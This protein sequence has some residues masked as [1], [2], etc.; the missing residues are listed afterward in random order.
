MEALDVV[1]AAELLGIGVDATVAEI[2]A[3]FRRVMWA[4]RPDQGHV[5]GAEMRR[6]GAARALLKARCTRHSATDTLA[7]GGQGVRGTG[8]TDRLPPSEGRTPDRT[9][10][11]T[12]TAIAMAEL[13]AVIVDLRDRPIPGA[14]RDD[15]GTRTRLRGVGRTVD[16]RS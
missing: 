16:V 13:A 12:P 7:R 6:L 2:D 5:G 15:W 3:A 1:V 9:P 4:R 11:P 8:R 10:D 14:T